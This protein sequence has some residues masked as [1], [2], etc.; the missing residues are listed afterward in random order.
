MS[1][2]KQ[3]LSVDDRPRQR[4]RQSQNRRYEYIRNNHH[5]FIGNWYLFTK[6]D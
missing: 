2:Y 4:W 5:R 6:V 1:Y 3:D